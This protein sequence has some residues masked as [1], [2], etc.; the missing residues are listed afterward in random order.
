M[1]NSAQTTTQEPV[2]KTINCTPTWQ[3]CASVFIA[4]LTQKGNKGKDDAAKELMKMAD[5]AQ[6][7]A[8]MIKAKGEFKMQ[9]DIGAVFTNKGNDRYELELSFIDMHILTNALFHYKYRNNEY[10]DKKEEHRNATEKLSGLLSDL[11]CHD[12]PTEQIPIEG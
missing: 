1:S 5:V 7:H 9:N 8:D 2:I 6:E 10:Y 4:V 11:Y 3:W 12:I